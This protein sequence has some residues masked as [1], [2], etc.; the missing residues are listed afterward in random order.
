MHSRRTPTSLP[1]VF[2]TLPAF[3]TWLVLVAYPPLAHSSQAGDS[4]PRRW[5]TYTTA[6][7]LPMNDVRA[8]YA[9]RDTV[10][11]LGTRGGGVVR[12]D[13]TTWT[14]F[15]T[16]DGLSGNGA[17]D[18][19]QDADGHLW[20]AG[21]GV[22]VWDGAR[23]QAVSP[24][25]GAASGT[26]YSILAD[27]DLG[28]LF[29]T[30]DGVC[31]RTGDAWSTVYSPAQ[32]LPHV[33]VHATLRDAHGSLWF[34]TRKGLARLDTGG[35]WTTYLESRNVRGLLED[36][37]GNLWFGTAGHG[38]IQF[39]GRNWK[40]FMPARNLAPQIVDRQGHVWLSSE[41]GGAFLVDGDEWTRFG[42]GD[43]LASTIVFDIAEDARGDIW[44][45][46]AGGVSR[47]RAP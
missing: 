35:T 7:G 42:P 21:A 19:H 34:A 13:G 20:C 22:S 27:P 25:S 28:L 38:V 26:A 16:A 24:D 43:G 23:W 12:F 6:D 1:R 37:Q 29:S 33:I 41:R 9:D 2:I 3:C 44:F 18:F 32:G 17:L 31:R 39:D 14:T 45:A 4:T 5:T 47:W 8:V 10:L 15:T 30:D 46:T 11:W 36:R 40:T